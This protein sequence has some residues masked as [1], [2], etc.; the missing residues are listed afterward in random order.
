[1]QKQ[2]Y[3]I[4]IDSTISTV[5]SE[6]IFNHPICM[7]FPLKWPMWSFD[8]PNCAHWIWDRFYVIRRPDPG[9]GGVGSV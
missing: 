3:H 9:R 4:T 5:E 8:E 1:L 2:G 7:L 6:V